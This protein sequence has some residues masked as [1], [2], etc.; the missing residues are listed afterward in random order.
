M[1]PKKKS[2]LG[3]EIQGRENLTWTD[4]EVELLL[5]VVRSYASQKNKGK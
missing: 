2:K 3:E 4:E 1:P 5:G